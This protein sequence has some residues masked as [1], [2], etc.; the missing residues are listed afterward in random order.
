MFALDYQMRVVWYTWNADLVWWCH[1][2]PEWRTASYTDS[3]R[4]RR[5]LWDTHH[6]RQLENTHASYHHRYIYTSN[7]TCMCTH[8]KQYIHYTANLSCLIVY[9]IEHVN[10]YLLNAT[11]HEDIINI[12][13]M[14]FCEAALKRC[15]NSKIHHY[16][17]F[18]S[19]SNSH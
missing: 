5:E 15:V 4:E 13:I 10:Y 19:M 11:K 9:I 14:I 12:N 3:E 6:D 16:T 7:F 1:H 2:I 8:V 18:L 17:I